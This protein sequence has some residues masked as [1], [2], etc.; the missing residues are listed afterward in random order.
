MI[1]NLGANLILFLWIAQGVHLTRLTWSDG[2]PVLS[3]IC[4]GA[5][6]ALLWPLIAVWI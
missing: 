3:G 5:T 6:L 4:A 1:G 2:H